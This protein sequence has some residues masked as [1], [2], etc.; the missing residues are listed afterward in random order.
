M[1]DLYIFSD[2]VI[3]LLASFFKNAVWVI[4]FFYLLNKTFESEKLMG[5]SKIAIILVLASFLLFSVVMT[6]L[7]LTGQHHFS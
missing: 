5:F 7:E 6:L 1:L 3:S 4:G 2:A